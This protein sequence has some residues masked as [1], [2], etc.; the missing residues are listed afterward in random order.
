M[1]EFLKHVDLGA[2]KWLETFYMDHP[3]KEAL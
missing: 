1:P 2:M 3:R